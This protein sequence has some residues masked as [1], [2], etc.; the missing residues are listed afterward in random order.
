MTTDKYD[1][2]LEHWQMFTI[3]GNRALYAA[4]TRLQKSIHR[5]NGRRIDL[6][7]LIKEMCKEVERKGFSEVWDTEP[8]VEIADWVNEHICAPNL[9]MP[10]ERWDW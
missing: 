10:I 4:V 7:M 6:S 8:Q 1:E 3:E 5:K 2:H 9:W